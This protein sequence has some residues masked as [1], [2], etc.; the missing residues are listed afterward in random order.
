MDYSAQEKVLKEK[1]KSVQDI[2]KLKEGSCKALNTYFEEIDWEADFHNLG[3]EK[4]S[5]RVS[6]FYN[7]GVERCVPTV[8]YMREGER[9]KK[10]EEGLNR[11]SRGR[12]HRDMRWKR[13]RK[14]G[15]KLH[16]A[17][18]SGHARMNKRGMKKKKQ[19]ISQK[20]TR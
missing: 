12:V 7:Q 6:E 17:D 5:I 9:E 10:I 1:K 14:T 16:L 19:F 15:V 8:R 3:I 2:R 4:R 18:T 13:Y 20:N 11:C